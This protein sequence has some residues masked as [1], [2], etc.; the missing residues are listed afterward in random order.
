MREHELEKATQF[1]RRAGV[2]PLWLKGLRQVWAPRPPCARCQRREATKVI[3]GDEPRAAHH[4]R[5]V[6]RV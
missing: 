2:S 3:G 4:P 1:T 5:R 6:V